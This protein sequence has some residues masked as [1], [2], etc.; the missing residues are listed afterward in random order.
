MKTLASRKLISTTHITKHTLRLPSIVVKPAPRPSI[1]YYIR[2]RFKD[3]STVYKI[4]YT[5]MN[6]DK[7]VNG[8]YDRR[9][10]RRVGGMGLPCGC[11]WVNVAILYK[12]DRE[13][14][15]RLEQDLHRQWAAERYYGPN[16][17]G[18]GNS[19]LYRRDILGLDIAKR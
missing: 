2:I 19:E 1:V 4:G 13:N 7:R 10:G 3:K 14:V 11:T 17:L 6:T 5:S 18:N 16:R 12:G 9:L 8:Y 15:F